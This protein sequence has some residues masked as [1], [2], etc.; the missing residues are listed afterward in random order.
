MYIYCM[1]FSIF[2]EKINEFRILKLKFGHAATFLLPIPREYT[3][4]KRET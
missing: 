3:T 1:Y 4:S 2:D